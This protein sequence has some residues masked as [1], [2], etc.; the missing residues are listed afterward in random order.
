MT[1]PLNRPSSR[2][3]LSAG[4]DAVITNFREVIE[5]RLA[6]LKSKAG[7]LFVAT[8]IDEFRTKVLPI[9]SGAEGSDTEFK[10]KIVPE[11][12]ENEVKGA[13]STEKGSKIKDG[14]MTLNAYVAFLLDFL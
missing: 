12:A 13:S 10:L 5:V 11:G 6:K 14:C 1:F 2:A 3:G 9:F 7:S 4:S 8:L